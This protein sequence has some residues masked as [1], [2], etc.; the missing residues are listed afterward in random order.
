MMAHAHAAPTGSTRDLERFERDLLRGWGTG[1]FSGHGK[2][3]AGSSFGSLFS[4]SL[5]SSGQV[6]YPS[7]FLLMLLP[8]P[9]HIT[10]SNIG[11]EFSSKLPILQEQRTISQCVVR[12]RD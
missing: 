8:E 10:I 1:S 5:P 2:P 9:L 6:C 11:N 12:V 7:F 4:S 3:P